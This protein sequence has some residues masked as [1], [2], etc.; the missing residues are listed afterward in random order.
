MTSDY[1]IGEII[2]FIP[3]QIDA[4]AYE[5][6]GATAIDEFTVKVYTESVNNKERVANQSP[7]SVSSILLKVTEKKN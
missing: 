4:Q 6:Q 3:Q 2:E 5:F 7:N 1:N